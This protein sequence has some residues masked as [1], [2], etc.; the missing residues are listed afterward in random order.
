MTELVS[1]AKELDDLWLGVK[2]LSKRRI[3]G[4]LRKIFTYR[5]NLKIYG[6]KISEME[7]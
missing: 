1:V 6:I 4:F 2:G 3:A 5:V 7:I